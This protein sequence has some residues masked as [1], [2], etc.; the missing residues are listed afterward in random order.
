MPREMVDEAR[1]EE[2]GF[3]Q[4]RNIWSSRPIED[5]WRDTGKAPVTVRWVDTNKGGKASF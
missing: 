4:G 1:Q 2:I 3:M 5:S